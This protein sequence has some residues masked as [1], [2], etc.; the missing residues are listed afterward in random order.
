MGYRR[1]HIL[2]VFVPEEAILFGKPTSATSEVYFLTLSQVC[3]LAEI[4]FLTLSQVCAL[5]K[6]KFIPTTKSADSRRRNPGKWLTL[7]P[8]IG[9]SGERV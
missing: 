6:H 4:R 5:G 2:S 3:A 7:V 8:A 9:S 1:H